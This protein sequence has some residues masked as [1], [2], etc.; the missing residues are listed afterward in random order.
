MF[1]TETN[2]ISIEQADS[3]IK[4]LATYVAAFND[5]MYRYK[6]SVGLPNMRDGF[7]VPLEVPVTP[8]FFNLNLP[9]VNT[10]L[11][12]V[13]A[14]AAPVRTQSKLINLL[15]DTV[16]SEIW[17]RVKATTLKVPPTTSKVE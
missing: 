5:D 16:R 12:F 3:E 8:G 17:T 6:Q 7:K 14:G 11:P 10:V 1:S 9:T 4:F 13:D 2:K 15:D